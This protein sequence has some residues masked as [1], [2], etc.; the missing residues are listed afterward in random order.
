MTRVPCQ[1]N[2]QRQSH[3]AHYWRHQYWMLSSRVHWCQQSS[4]VY[5]NPSTMAYDPAAFYPLPHLPPTCTVATRAHTAS[6]E[7]HARAQ[8]SRTQTDACQEH[9]SRN[10]ISM[11]RTNTQ[12][13]PASPLPS[14]MFFCMYRR[15]ELRVEQPLEDAHVLSRMMALEWNAMRWCTRSMLRWNELHDRDTVRY[16]RQMHMWNA[17]HSFTSSHPSEVHG[18]WGYRKLL[19]LGYS[20]PLIFDQ[21]V[22]SE[23]AVVKI[24]KHG[25]A[26]PSCTNASHM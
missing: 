8:P 9:V 6:S 3:M 18:D 22:C 23:Q 19:S 26:C 15:P 5:S 16:N 7:Y 20:F 25:T 24:V 12:G 1:D 14:F 2:M 17:S 4:H 11:N 21:E 10:Q 13:A